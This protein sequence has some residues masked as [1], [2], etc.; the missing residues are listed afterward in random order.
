MERKSFQKFLDEVPMMGIGLVL[1]TVVYLAKRC[2]GYSGLDDP[3]TPEEQ[4]YIADVLRKHGMHEDADELEKH[5]RKL[6]KLSCNEDED[7]ISY[8]AK[9]DE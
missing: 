6:K 1:R 2:V 9:I 4:I 5:V 3:L 8:L 7:A